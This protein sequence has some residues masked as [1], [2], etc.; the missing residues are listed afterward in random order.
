MQ[1]PFYKN[2][3]NRV[4]SPGETYVA[5]NRSYLMQGQAS[6]MEEANYL[7]NIVLKNGGISSMMVSDNRL[8][9]T[10]NYIDRLMGE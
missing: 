10:G 1:Q 2:M 5:Q 6:S 4:Q 8:P 3:V 9:I 7:N